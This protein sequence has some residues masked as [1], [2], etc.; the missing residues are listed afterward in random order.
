M[1]TQAIFELG[2]EAERLLQLAL[3]NLNTLKTTSFT[4]QQ[5]ENYFGQSPTGSVVPPKFCPRGIQVQQ[6]LL[7]NELRKI[8]QH[9]MVLAIVGT[10]KA[11]KSTTINAIIG[12]EVLPNRNRPMTALPTLIRHTPGQREPVLHF[13][14]VQPIE[15]L[16][17]ALQLR[18]QQTERETLGRHLEI[19]RD[20]AGLLT[21]ITMGESFAKHYLGAQPI[22]HCLKSLNDLVRLS[23]ALD[24]AFPFKAYAAIEHVPVIEVEFVHLAGINESYGQLTLLDTPGPNEAGQ[25]HLQKMLQEQLAQASAVLAVLDYTQLKSVSDEDVRKAILGASSSVPL[26]VLVNKFD[27]KDRNGDDEAQVKTLISDTLMKGVIEPNHVFPVSSMWGY[28]A[29]RARHELALHGMLPDPDE[30]RWVQDFADAALGRRWRSS[31]LIDSESLRQ[32][33]ELLW[34]DSQ[35]ASP[36]KKVLHAAHANASMYALRSACQKLLVYTQGAEDYLNFRCQGL[37]IA[38]EQLQRNI[39]ALEDDMRLATDSQQSA[40]AVAQSNVNQAVQTMEDF[41]RR[42]ELQINANIADYFL[43]GTVPEKLTRQ[44]L[45]FGTR[46]GIDFDARNETLSFDDEQSAQIALHRIRA[47][48]EVILTAAQEKMTEELMHLFSFLE[49]ELADTLRNTLKPIEARVAQGLTQAGFRTNI[50]LPVFHVGLLNFNANQAFNQLIEEQ[51]IPVAQLRRPAGMRG[52]VARWLNSDEWG[53]EGYTVMQS[54]YVISLPDVQRKL[55]EHIASFLLQL[56]QTMTVQ[57]EYAVSEG[58]TAFFA[59]F[60][61]ALDAIHLN[62]QQS[63]I[64]RQQNEDA[65]TALRQQLQQCLRTTRYIHED[66]RLL[67]DDIQTLFTVE[68]P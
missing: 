1:Y 36:I 53:W 59:D 66:T 48:C 10:V 41:I 4:T 60:S 25:P 16:M 67:R 30:H 21:R 56:N 33:A 47:S 44:A 8:T 38:S 34:E 54:R 32:S 64:A 55:S 9:E 63:L 57:I 50:S 46:R 40:S 24:V 52:T 20:M 12:T 26:Y 58:M 5:D 61:Q 11:G 23:K 27:Q 51:D 43:Q 22:F 3:Q 65:V 28:L 19:D 17:Q 7:Q 6:A 14:Y 29:N 45:S 2:Q 35:F 62:L 42:Y 68:Q 31:D 37:R 39:A 13:P 15:E 49:V 18:L